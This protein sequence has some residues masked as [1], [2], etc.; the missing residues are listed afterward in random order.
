M[1]KQTLKNLTLQKKTISHLAK[2]NTIKGGAHKRS[3]LWYCETDSCPQDPTPETVFP[4]CESGLGAC[5]M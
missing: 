1:K 5:P 3:N 4:R 2:K